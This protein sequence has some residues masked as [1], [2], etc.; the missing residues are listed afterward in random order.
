MHIV[1]YRE[2]LDVAMQT[3]PSLPEDFAPDVI[4]GRAIIREALKDNRT[5]L[6]PIEIT[7]LFAAYAIPI[8]SAV[9]ARDPQEAVHAATPLL[10]EGKTVVVKISSPDIPTKSDVG[11]VRL[12]LTKR[13]CRPRRDRG[14]SRARPR[15][16]AGCSYRWRHRASNDPAAPRT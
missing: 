16:E 4:A 8:A 5:W 10:A 9:L 13:T 2:G 7:D 11:G 12:N 3:P 1:R 14:N 6:S 15:H